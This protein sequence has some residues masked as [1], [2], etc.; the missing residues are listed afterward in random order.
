MQLPCQL[1]GRHSIG[2]RAGLPRWHAGASLACLPLKPGT[3]LRHYSE[4]ACSQLQP[5]LL[6]STCSEDEAVPDI[7][8]ILWLLWPRGHSHIMATHWCMYVLRLVRRP[9]D[10]L[11]RCCTVIDTATLACPTRTQRQCSRAGHATRCA[12]QPVSCLTFNYRDWPTERIAMRVPAAQAR[13]HRQPMQLLLAE[14]LSQR[15]RKA[16]PDTQCMPGGQT[17]GPHTSHLVKCSITAQQ[18]TRTQSLAP[19]IMAMQML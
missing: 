1:A 17:D 9:H 18:P 4:S 14:A 6:A 2:V 19:S 13:C 7:H 10:H 5:G 8:Y 16:V 11:Q 15:A 3:T 12:P